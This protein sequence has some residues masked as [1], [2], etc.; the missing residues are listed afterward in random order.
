MQEFLK[1]IGE[2]DDSA[3]YRLPTEAEWE[4]A[5]RSGSNTNF[6][7][8]PHFNKDFVFYAGNSFGFAEYA[9]DVTSCPNK[10]VDYNFPG[11]CGN[12][13]GLMHMS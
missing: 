1:R 12:F 4:F 6:Y 11:Y 8:G 3:T 5:A 2:L 13:Y 9:R 7:W 10:F